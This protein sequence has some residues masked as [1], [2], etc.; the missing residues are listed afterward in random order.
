M[1]GVLQMSFSRHCVYCEQ[2]ICC[3]GLG[4]FNQHQT[5]CSRKRDR[6]AYAAYASGQQE[7]CD[8]G[9]ESYGWES[10]PDQAACSKGAKW[11]EPQGDGA[12]S[13]PARDELAA[14]DL[15][16]CAPATSLTRR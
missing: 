10:E 12:D 13:A 1:W 3:S 5:S 11:S 2:T 4:G 15:Q 16:P 6:A 14:V 9:S 8:D 7:P